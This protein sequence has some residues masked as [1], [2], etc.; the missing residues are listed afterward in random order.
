MS[1]YYRYF[2]NE[3]QIF[4]NP[5]FIKATLAK[6]ILRNWGVPKIGILPEKATKQKQ[7]WWMIRFLNVKPF[8]T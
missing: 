3:N 1:I 8:G 2:G 6:P 4:G 5:N 7:F